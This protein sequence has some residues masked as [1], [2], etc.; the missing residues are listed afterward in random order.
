MIVSEWLETRPKPSSAS[1]RQLLNENRDQMLIGDHLVTDDELPLL[2]D[3]INQ[4][5]V[6]SEHRNLPMADTYPS[7]FTLLDDLF[8][9]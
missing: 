3:F 5:V 2:L 1:V 7:A 9:F 6:E 8:P 4:S